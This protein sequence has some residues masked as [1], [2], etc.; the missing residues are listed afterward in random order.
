MDA[1][2]TDGRSIAITT[3][4]VSRIVLY[5]P[6][7]ARAGK[8]ELDVIVDGSK[9]TVA[10]G[11]EQPGFET[12]SQPGPR[13]PNTVKA[14][15]R[16]IKKD[17]QW[18]DFGNQQ[19]F[20]HDGPDGGKPWSHPGPIDSAFKKRFLMVLPD[21]QSASPEVAAW[22]AAES[23]HFLRRWRGLMRGDVRVVN[24]AEITD[25][26]AA[27]AD[28]GLILWGTPESNSVLKKIIDRL[29]LKWS[30]E[31]LE[32]AGKSYDAT[33]HVPALI[34]P[35]L[36]SANFEVVIN[37]GLTFREAHD[38]TNSL[39]NPKLPDWA[40]LDITTPASPEQAGRVV[41]TDFFDEHWQVR[42]GTP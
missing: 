19:S 4:N 23:A 9:L 8:T 26:V 33:T 15:V 13:Q 6:P 40:I 16:L 31:Q 1:K 36:G 14:F 24:A 11:P 28:Q 41:A 38:R 10:L 37:S 21:G 2:V 20:Q 30:P 29:P 34:Y 27:G 12:F 35:A 32:I 3:S 17:G 7:Q 18:T 42:S 22:V 5:P 25:P 39:Q